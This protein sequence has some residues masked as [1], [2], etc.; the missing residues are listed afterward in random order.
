MHAHDVFERQQPSLGDDSNPDVRLP[1]LLQANAEL[2]DEVV[3]ALGGAR[4]GVVRRGRRPAT[5]QLPCYVPPEAGVR[6]PID[7]PSRRDC[8]IDETLQQCLVAATPPALRAGSWTPFSTLHFSL[9]TFHF[10]LI[11]SPSP[12]P[13]THFIHVDVVA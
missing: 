13:Q 5:H 10:S 6:K 7:K 9:L 3:P 11:R 8:E 4:F 2:V 12:L 1:E